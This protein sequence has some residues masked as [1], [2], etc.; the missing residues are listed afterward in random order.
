MERKRKREEMSGFGDTKLCHQ[1]FVI[2]SILNIG[3]YKKF[4]IYFF[5]RSGYFRVRGIATANENNVGNN[6]ILLTEQIV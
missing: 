3:K 2:E 1:N 5:F 6:Y 4:Y